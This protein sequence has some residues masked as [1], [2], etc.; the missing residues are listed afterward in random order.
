VDW[1]IIVSKEPRLE[2]VCIN[3]VL[4]DV[5]GSTPCIDVKLGTYE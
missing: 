2:E 4:C 3:P 5:A 1:G